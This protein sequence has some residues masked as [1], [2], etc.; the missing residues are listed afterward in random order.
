MHSTLRFY[1]ILIASSVL[2][3]ASLQLSLY[4][5]GKY[6]RYVIVASSIE[7]RVLIKRV[8]AVAASPLPLISNNFL[9][10]ACPLPNVSPKL[11]MFILLS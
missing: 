11:A 2:L 5:L 3:L 6:C 1:L 8:I 4:P 9:T 10:A 7:V